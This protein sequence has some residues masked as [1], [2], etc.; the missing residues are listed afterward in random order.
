MTT[1]ESKTIVI[2]CSQPV[3]FTFLSDFNHF[4]NLM[5]EQ[6]VNWKSDADSCSF[7]IRGMADVSLR[8][9]ERQPYTAIVIDQQGAARFPLKMTVLTGAKGEGQTEV[10]IVIR[11]GLNT[12]QSMLMVTPLTNLVNILVNRLKELCE[13]THLKRPAS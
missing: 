4:E 9:S 7:T 5:P 10:K 11:A 6:I 3:V 13:Q 8:I 2:N 12:F 1:I